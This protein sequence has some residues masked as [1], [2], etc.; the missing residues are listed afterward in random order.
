MHRG[1]AVWDNFPN[2][3]DINKM[4]VFKRFSF[5]AAHRLPSLGKDHRCNRVHG[6]TFHLEVR[7]TGKVHPKTGMVVSFEDIKAVVVPLLKNLDHHYLN[8]ISGLGLPTTENL[9]HY[10]WE[11]MKPKLPKLSEI[12]L[13]ETATAGVIYRGPNSDS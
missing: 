8:D 7:C 3:F 1:I 9:A 5:D 12:I 6:H 13:Q 11:R 4:I 10:L 2:Y